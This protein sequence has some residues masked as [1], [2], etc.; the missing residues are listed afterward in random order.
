MLMTIKMSGCQDPD[1]CILTRDTGGYDDYMGIFKNQES[2]VT[3][4]IDSGKEGVLLSGCINLD[5]WLCGCSQM[6]QKAGKK[7]LTRKRKLK[8]SGLWQKAW[9]IFCRI[10]FAKHDWCRK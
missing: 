9:Q 8:N 1:A 3:A 7:I 10:R 2:A 5:R 6:Q 4:A